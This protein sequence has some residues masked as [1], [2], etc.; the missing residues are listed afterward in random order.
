ME[1]RK[2]SFIPVIDVFA[3]PGGLGEG[4]SALRE[5]ADHPFRIRLSVEKDKAAWETLSLRSFFRHFRAEGLPVPDEY[6]EHVTEPKTYT[7]DELFKRF[8]VQAK[9]ASEEAKCLQLGHSLSR[10][11]RTALTSSRPTTS[12]VLKT[13]VFPK[14]GTASSCWASAETC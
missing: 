5:K 9:A 11:R 7:R 8:P 10:S 3:G 4:F 14:Q 2:N 12:C 1:R 6:Y 13:M